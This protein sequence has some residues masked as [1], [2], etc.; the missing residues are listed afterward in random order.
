MYGSTATT[1]NVQFGIWMQNWTLSAGRVKILNIFKPKLSP[2]R[3]KNELHYPISPKKKNSQKAEVICD[4][5]F[6]KSWFIKPQHYSHAWRC[7]SA[8]A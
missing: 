2:D 1:H 5:I 4:L 8:L 6:D 7:F 3:V